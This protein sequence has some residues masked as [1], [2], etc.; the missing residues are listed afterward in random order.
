[1]KGWGGR[2]EEQ[3]PE[4]DSLQTDRQ[5]KMQEHLGESTKS[6]VTPSKQG[7]AWCVVRCLESRRRTRG[8]ESHHPCQHGKFEVS[9]GHFRSYL[10]QYKQNDKSR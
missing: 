3:L 6:Q 4:G 5:S 1:M 9:L 10:K 2:P 7:E 8:P